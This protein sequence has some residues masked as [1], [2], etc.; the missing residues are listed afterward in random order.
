M[1][2]KDATGRLARWSLLLQQFNFDIVHRPGCQ[3]RNADAL[4]R[5]PYPDTNLN[6]LN[7]SDPEIDKIREKQQ[8]DRSVK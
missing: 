1:N 6:A 4:S 2:V 8:K 7:Q 3:N 5:R